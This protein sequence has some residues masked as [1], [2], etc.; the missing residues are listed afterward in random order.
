MARD[1]PNDR[2]PPPILI[3]KEID[4]L[5]WPAGGRLS[6]HEHMII[7]DS[8]RGIAEQKDH[9][10]DREGKHNVFYQDMRFWLII[11]MLAAFLAFI[12]IQ[13]PA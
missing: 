12:F 13:Y 5:A 1:L 6:Y 2:C 7:G 8:E 10:K 9:L 3:T 4:A 11:L